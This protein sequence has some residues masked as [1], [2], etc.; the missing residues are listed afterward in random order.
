M[1]NEEN[2]QSLDIAA[3]Q[4]SDIGANMDEV[5][6]VS[7]E[8]RTL[9]VPSN[10][11]IWFACNLVTTTML[12]GMLFIPGISFGSALIAIIIGCLLGIIPLILIGLI[13]QK[14]GLVTMV[15]SRATFGTKGALLPSFINLMILI[16]WSWA[17]AALG[18]LALD[19]GIKTLTGYSNPSLFIVVCEVVVITV[20]LYAIKGIALYEKIAMVLIAII[21]GA[22]IVR[23]ITTVGFTNIFEIPSDPTQG[24]TAIAAFDI[25][26]ATALSWTPL[27]ADYNRNCKSRK[28]TVVGTGGG[29]ALGTIL[30][31]GSGAVMIGMI[32][33]GGLTLSYEPSMVFAEIGFGLAGAVVIFLSIVAANV[34]CIYSATMSFLNAFPK[35]S[36]KKV[37]ITIGVICVLG[38]LFSGIL[39]AFLNFVG[40]IGVL[41]MPI[42]AIM[43]ADFYVVK[44]Q[45]VNIDAIVYPEKYDDYKY[46]GGFN[47]VAIA[48]FAIAAV[49][50]FIFTIL[51]PIP[52]GATIPTFFIAFLGYILAMKII[53]SK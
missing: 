38:A 35:F 16:A 14:T 4:Q 36:Y 46:S 24:L 27:A 22:V 23:A 18:G 3:N 25:V 45:K 6:P 20:A 8:K 52:T 43:I 31:M 12:T 33:A 44:K 1:K 28:A 7:M 50:A 11:A 32:I 5:L 47:I 49:F 9:G 34:M 13:G 39:D 10:F 40:I 51:Y 48:V 37:A 42:F 2:G 17:Q 15:A 19:Y 26:V 30:S 53:E 29:Y 41:F 21:M